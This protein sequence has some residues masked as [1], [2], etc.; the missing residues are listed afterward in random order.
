MIY[1]HHLINLKQKKPSGPAFSMF[2]VGFLI[3]LWYHIIPC[4]TPDMFLL[5]ALVVYSAELQCFFHGF[6]VKNIFLTSVNNSNYAKLN[7]NFV[8]TKKFYC[9]FLVTTATVLIPSGSIF[10]AILRL[11]LVDG[12]VLAVT[13]AKIIEFEYILLILL[14]HVLCHYCDQLNNL[15]YFQFPNAHRQNFETRC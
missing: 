11:S 15:F 3:D 10:L 12:S 9:V 14:A 8:T 1:T 5:Y 6:I 4:V 13:T 2:L 7:R